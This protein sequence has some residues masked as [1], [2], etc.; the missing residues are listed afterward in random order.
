ML[1]RSLAALARCWGVFALCLTAACPK[2]E[3]AT[4]NPCTVSGVSQQID[5]EGL[6]QVDL[7]FV[8]DDSGSMA[9]EQ[10]KLAQELPRLV[11]VL[12]SGDRFAG[13]TPP[14]GIS[15]EERFFTKVQ[16]LHLGVVSTN[17]GGIDDPSESLR[18]CEGL[19]DDGK[20]L[21]STEI[22]RSGVVAASADEFP[23]FELGETVL[24][25]D[26]SCAL[27]PA[28]KYQA[29]EAASGGDAT[30]TAHTFACVSRL[31]VHGCAFE[32]Q[33]E[34]M[35]KAL[36]P[37]AG[38]GDQFAFLNGTKG[39]GDAFN[40]GF[41][42]PEAVLAV[43]HVSDEEDCSIKPE[44][45]ELFRLDAA[46]NE[47]FGPRSAINV[48]CSKFGASQ[49]LLWPAQRYID[50]LRSLKP[51]HP[52]RIV[53]GAIVGIPEDANGTADLADLLARPELAFDTVEIKGNTFERPSCKRERGGKK[54]EATPPRRFIEVAQGFADAQVLWSICSDD[55]GPAL[56][57]L[58]DRIASKLKGNCLPRQLSRDDDGQVQCEL[59]EL[60]GPDVGEC[61]EARGHEG[62]PLAHTYRDGRGK[63]QTRKACVMKQV[64]VVD[65]MPKRAARGW[66]YDDFAA[67]LA[68]DCEQGAQQRISFQ[69][70]DNEVDLPAGASV[71]YA[72]FQSVTRTEGEL[73]G[74]GAV[75]TPCEPTGGDGD[76]L[77]CAQKSNAAEGGYDLLCV[78]RK[79]QITCNVTPDCPAGW[80]CSTGA[81]GSDGP[82]RYCQ[83]PTC[84]QQ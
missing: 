80:V 46:A 58:I 71:A 6:S 55:Y 44:G 13:R 42:R 29:Y 70:A 5:Q 79:C 68:S 56:D 37:A 54:E 3:L 20:L 24:P 47:R 45:K 84:P 11:R 7:L 35:W 59:V 62:R 63:L 76:M 82:P 69:F 34:A 52:D 38:K 14:A 65:G 31:G 2:Q 48:R 81:A 21:R 51:E 72:C 23:G 83:L 61:S 41:L 53:F 50:G 28:L 16:S 26:P 32:Q 64:P 4:L 78:E 75:N 9:A 57:R 19:G 30:E 66:Y 17:M 18:A 25:A 15:A 10:Q 43:I 49:Q 12:T 8:I 74:L 40:A 77:S 22:A 36:A 27:A 33:L 73:K 1:K 67:S 39:H 60:L